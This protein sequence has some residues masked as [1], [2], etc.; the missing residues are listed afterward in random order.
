MITWPRQ[1][2]VLFLNSVCWAKEDEMYV[3][4]VPLSQNTITNK[5]LNL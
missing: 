1:Y 3:A 4:T 2:S 5:K